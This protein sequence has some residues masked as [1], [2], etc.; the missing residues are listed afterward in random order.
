MAE[1]QWALYRA[2]HQ[3]SAEFTKLDSLDQGEAGATSDGL[4]HART[5][6]HVPLG[7]S[8]GPDVT[9]TRDADDRPWMVAADGGTSM[10][11]VPGWFGYS[12]WAYFHI[13]E[14]TTYCDA[15]LF[16][17]R[18]K[19]NKWNKTKSVKGRHYTIRPAKAMTLA[20]YLGELD[21]LARAA[22]VRSVA[23]GRTVRVHNA[24]DATASD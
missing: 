24:T 9:V 7:A 22:V 13:P 15:N 23:L 14:G 3:T 12:T 19:K 18:D 10:H 8:G 20:T 21:N 17:K 4:I 5:G 6:D 2:I 1:T 16:I 11:D